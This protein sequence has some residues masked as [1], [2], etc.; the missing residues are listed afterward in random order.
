[1]S[2]IWLHNG[3]EMGYPAV[4]FDYIYSPC[5]PCNYPEVRQN[6]IIIQYYTMPAAN[7]FSIRQTHV[8]AVARQA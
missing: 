4:A 1:M 5:T 7:A 6:L 3:F 2:S 8:P